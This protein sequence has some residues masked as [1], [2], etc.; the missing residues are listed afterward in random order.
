M[1]TIKMNELELENLN[2]TKK[3]STSHIKYFMTII[4]IVMFN[5]KSLTFNVTI[6]MWDKKI[7][8]LSSS[9]HSED[10]LDH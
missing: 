4:K 3:F 6:I 1:S 9:F 5:I 2:A 7:W 8:R 10:A